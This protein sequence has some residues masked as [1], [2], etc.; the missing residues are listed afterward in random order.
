MLYTP[1]VYNFNCNLVSSTA[2]KPCNLGQ[3]AVLYTPMFT[4][5][6]VT[7]YLVQQSKLVIRPNCSALYTSIHNFNRNLVFSTAIQLVLRPDSSALY[8]SVYNF[9]CNL[10][11]STATKPVIRLD[12]SALYTSACNFNCS[13]VFSTAIQACN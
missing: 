1:I 3:I 12:C 7:L 10:A 2:K 4:N 9:N 13:L 8:T 11:I 6:M 5:S